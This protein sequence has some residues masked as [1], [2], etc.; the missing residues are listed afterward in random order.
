MHVARTRGITRVFRSDAFS[1]VVET[2][3][4]NLSSFSS[5]SYSL[6]TKF[7]D[8]VSGSRVYLGQ[9]NLRSVYITEREV[10]TENIMFFAKNHFPRYVSKYIF[11]QTTLEQHRFEKGLSPHSNFDENESQVKSIPDVSSIVLPES[12]TVCRSP[13][14]VINT[15][16]RYYF[17]LRAYRR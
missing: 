4:T 6:I 8:R 12:H 17:P 1:R 16:G 2:R 14:S 9:R 5:S 7:R 15:T 10:A 11:P 3:Y 13:I